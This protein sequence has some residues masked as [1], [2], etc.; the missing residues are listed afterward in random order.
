MCRRKMA[1][2]VLKEA[3]STTVVEATEVE[4][5]AAKCWCCGLVEE[6]TQAYI[7]RV[8]DRYSGRWICG[9]CAEAVKEERERGEVMITM[10]EALMR[11]VTFCQKFKS[12]TPNNDVILAVKQILFRTLDSPR[13]DRFICRPLGRSQSCF[14]N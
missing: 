6:C 1:G 7:R 14:S 13:K 4:T 12:S 10:E 9:L 8:R 2:N 11:H 3:E 5:A